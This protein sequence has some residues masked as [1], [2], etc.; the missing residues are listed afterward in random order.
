MLFMKNIIEIKNLDFAYNERQIFNDLNLTIKEGTY[1]V[2]LG[3]N[4]SGKSTLARILLGLL[5]HKGEILIDGTI[6]NEDNLYEIRNKIGIVF[7]NPDNQFIGSTVKD[8]IAFGLENHCVK[9]EDMDNI[10]NEFARKVGMEEFL[11]KEPS[12]LSGGQKQRVAIAGV[13][14]MNPSILI[15]DEATSMLDPKGKREIKELIYATKVAN[16]N[17]TIISITHDIEETQYADNVII[18]NE[19]KVYK[20]GTPDEIFS[21]YQELI[22]IGLD[23]PFYDKVILSLNNK[24]MKISSRSKEELE[25]KICQ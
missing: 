15:F 18:L 17:L 8:D 4:G 16:P 11:E 9:H 3:R 13:L 23:V 25:K 22:N 12:H 1:N 24:G 7:Q 2:I 10:I 5:D 20:S 19:G 6:L 14:A 21:N